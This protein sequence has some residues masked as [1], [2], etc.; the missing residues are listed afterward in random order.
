[1]N[2]P[3]ASTRI[4]NIIMIVLCIGCIL[5]FALSF[6]GGEITMLGFPI[7]F[8]LAAL[9][10]F[11]QAWQRFRKDIRGKNQKGA[12]IAFLIAGILMLCVSYIMIFCLWV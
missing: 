11:F 1:M 10:Q 6:R 3:T 12:G 4:G 7:L 9:M 2:D 8:F 5:S